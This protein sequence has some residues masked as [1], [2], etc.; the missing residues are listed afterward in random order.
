LKDSGIDVD[1]ELTLGNVVLGVTWAHLWKEDLS[2]SQE[3]RA[4][5]GRDELSYLDD[6]V[7]GKGSTWQ[8]LLSE[9]EAGDWKVAAIEHRNVQRGVSTEEDV[10][11]SPIVLRRHQVQSL[12]LIRLHLL[13]IYT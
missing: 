2:Q 10:L 13:G 5:L 4:V 1:H 12:E 9:I 7:I 11:M 3:L 8:Y 6:E